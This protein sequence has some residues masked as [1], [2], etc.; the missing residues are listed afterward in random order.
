M[1][2]SALYALTQMEYFPDVTKELLGHRKF[3][4]QINSLSTAVKYDE[5]TMTDCILH[6]LFFIMK[7]A[8]ETWMELGEISSQN[9]I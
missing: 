7:Y 8:V 1:Y 9:M 2:V 3:G 6:D 5:R 4:P